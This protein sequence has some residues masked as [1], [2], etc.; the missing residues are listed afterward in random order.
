LGVIGQAAKP[1]VFRQVCMPDSK[2]VRYN[3]QTNAWMDREW[4][5]WWFDEVFVPRARHTG[6]VYLL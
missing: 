3:S 5:Q 1:K 4:C 6:K 2:W